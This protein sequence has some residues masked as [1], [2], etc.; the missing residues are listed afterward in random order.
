MTDS[1]ARFEKLL[2]SH[3]RL[4]RHEGLRR[5]ALG[6]V[7]AVTAETAIPPLWCAA[8]ELIEQRVG[9][10]INEGTFRHRAEEIERRFPMLS[11][12]AGLRN[13]DPRA[14]SALTT[15]AALRPSPVE[16]A[17]DAARGERLHAELAAGGLAVSSVA[18]ADSA[19]RPCGAGL[20]PA[21]ALQQCLHVQMRRLRTACPR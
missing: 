17:L 16:A 7:Q 15:M 14:A 1:A 2:L 19:R 20:D 18:A 5:F 13:H 3:A 9:R 6:C 8:I 12:V 11:L 4:D 21:R 10:A